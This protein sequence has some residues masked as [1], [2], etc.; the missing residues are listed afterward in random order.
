MELR[1]VIAAVL[2]SLALSPGPAFADEV[3]LLTLEDAIHMAKAQNYQLKNA[4]LQIDVVDAQKKAVAAKRYP[5]LSAQVHGLRNF[6]DN[7]YTFEEGSLG[8][9]AGSPVP[10]SNVAIGT[11]SGFTTHYSLTATQPLV[12][13]YEINLNVDKLETEKEIARQQSRQAEQSIA[14]QVKQLYYHI[15][16]SESTIAA[17]T[18]SVRFNEELVKIL[19]DNVAAKTELEYQLLNGEA[20]LAAARH[21]LFADENDMLTSKQ[22]LNALLGRNIATAFR[23]TP[24]GAEPEATYDTAVAADQALANRPETQEARLQ[25]K[26][27]E[28]DLEINKSGYLPEV[29]LVAS[30][31]R[32]EKTRLLPDESL[33]VGV[34]AKWDFFTWGANENK[35][36]GA[37]LALLQA[38]N[39]L[40]DNEDQIRAEVSQNI[41]NLEV[42][43]ALVPVTELAKKAAEEALRVSF[44][45]YKEK[46]ILLSDLLN[47]QSELEDAND[48]YHQA[49]LGV[50]NASAAL[51]QALGAE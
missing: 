19:G 7:E 25:V 8:T 14:L 23:V 43:R 16:S 36:S 41:R 30:Y 40:R 1:P 42:A 6:E 45:Q 5:Q 51:E 22:Q 44:N 48:N 38:Q 18:A 46:A 2:L 37:R 32:S 12:G 27:A 29:N 17:A 39:A 34:L 4:G 49:L 33:Y 21:Q 10:S 15:L 24:Q 9:V 20:Q 47:A 26:A 50:W 13:L 11:S 3:P 28:T 31:G 35:V